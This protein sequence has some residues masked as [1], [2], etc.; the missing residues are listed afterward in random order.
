MQNRPSA[1]FFNSGETSKQD[2]FKN[3]ED[4]DIWNNVNHKNKVKKKE[5]NKN[6][7]EMQWVSINISLQTAYAGIDKPNSF[8]FAHSLEN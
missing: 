5:K 2:R 1:N 3:N 7:E 8:H 6:N 4:G